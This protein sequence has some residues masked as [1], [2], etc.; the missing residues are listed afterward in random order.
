MRNL[1]VKIGTVLFVLL[2]F[3]TNASAQVKLKVWSPLDTWQESLEY[4]A[5]HLTEFKKLHPDVD[6]DFVHIPYENYEA[7]YLTAFAS[8]KDAPDIFNGKVAYYAGAI[9]VAD[10]A[11]DDL[12]EL[13]NDKL[14]NVTKPFFQIDGKWYAYPTS[15][16]T[17]MMVYYNVDHFN[18]AG[19][20]P[21]KPPR[22]FDELLEYA[23]KLTKYDDN[24]KITRNGLAVR[25]AARRSA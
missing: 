22:T 13:W 19:L 23:K 7:K 11:P 14:L 18:E 9:G 15:S 2:A 25:Y 5:D 10:V 6:I 3:A 21:N 4:Y 17:G 1:F 8:K 12:Q 20:D 16:D 24:G